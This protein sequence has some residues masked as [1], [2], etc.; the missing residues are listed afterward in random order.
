[1]NNMPSRQEGGRFDLRTTFYGLRNSTPEE[2]ADIRARLTAQTV[3]AEFGCDAVTAERAIEFSTQRR[4][5]LISQLRHYV[6]EAST[7]NFLL[8]AQRSKDD[9]LD[10][11]HSLRRRLVGGGIMIGFA[12]G[13]ALLLSFG[14]GTARTAG[15]ASTEPG[16]STIVPAPREED[17]IPQAE[18]SKRAD[19]TNDTGGGT[20]NDSELRASSP[21]TLTDTRIAYS[22]PTTTNPEIEKG[23]GVITETTE[24]V[25]TAEITGTSTY[26]LTTSLLAKT[27][28]DKVQ[29]LRS[30]TTITNL[31]KIPTVVDNISGVPMTVSVSFAANSQEY[32]VELPAD[33]ASKLFKP[34]QPLTLT[35]QQ[36]QEKNYPD[37]VA[38]NPNSTVN[39]RGGAGTNYEVKDQII[40]GA[41]PSALGVI[42]KKIVGEDIWYQLAPKGYWGFGELFRAVETENTGG[43]EDAAERA[44]I[45]RIVEQYLREKK[46]IT[47][48]SLLD[49]VMSSIDLVPSPGSE[50]K[51]G[52]IIGIL[53]SKM[54]RTVLF[55]L[56]FDGQTYSFS[57][58]GTMLLADL[59]RGGLGETEPSAIVPQVILPTPTPTAT[60]PAVQ[61]VAAEK[62]VATATSELVPTAPPKATE[63]IPALQEIQLGDPNT[64]ALVVETTSYIPGEIVSSGQ[65]EGMETYQLLAVMAQDPST[66]RMPY[67]DAAGNVV[68]NTFWEVT[69]AWP[70]YPLADGSWAKACVAI[71]AELVT[72]DGD[73]E[74]TT[75]PYNVFWWDEIKDNQVSISSGAAPANKIFKIK[76][77]AGYDAAKQSVTD[78]FGEGTRALLEI[79]LDNA[80]NPDLEATNQ[81][82]KL[83]GELARSLWN[84]SRVS[85]P[86]DDVYFP[87]FSVINEAGLSSIGATKG[88]VFLG[89]TGRAFVD[90]S[91]N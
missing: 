43:A 35:E 14:V 50:N 38:P 45:H 73:T 66:I 12:L 61:E 6:G 68:P 44:T 5:A 19:A 41:N 80:N 85:S 32:T 46:G 74:T 13:L 52:T 51:D 78:L 11:L 79:G 65:E 33:K 17:E 28:A 37:F 70:G 87:G 3:A 40:S 24:L 31:V 90:S 23:D 67:T 21:V 59:I 77:D 81:A 86:T 36:F 25:T 49:R 76:H 69:C 71:W 26:T 58:F 4:A 27:E 22:S 42:G 57:F 18:N 47:D 2:V 48:Q 53:N 62:P 56:T 88:L 15:A 20:G 82:F 83:R 34:T 9:A 7:Q 39:L 84:Q 10:Y 54:G 8:K 89:L 75:Y 60:R 16:Q 72:K 29:Y 64:Y 1:M 91:Q 55:E 30:G 63:Q